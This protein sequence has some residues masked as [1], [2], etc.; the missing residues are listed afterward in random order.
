LANHHDLM[1]PQRRHGPVTLALSP[2]M[3]ILSSLDVRPGR[4][5]FPLYAGPVRIPVPAAFAVLSLAAGAV[6]LVVG[7]RARAK[8]RRELEE[9]PGTKRRT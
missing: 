4:R 3:A 1:D 6:F 2:I 5:E 8:L 7:T 9:E